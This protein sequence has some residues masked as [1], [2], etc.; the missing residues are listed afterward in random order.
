MSHR[1]PARR[2]PGRRRPRCRRGRCR[3][4][5]D[6]IVAKALRAEPAH[7]YATVGRPCGATSRRRVAA[8]ARGGTRRCTGLFRRPCLAPASLVRGGHGA[9][10]R[11]A[12][13]RARRCRLAGAPGRDGARRGAARRPRAEEALR[14]HLT[15]LF[16]SA[17]ADHGASSPTAKNMLDKSAR[18][19]LDE[20]RDQPVLAGP[21]GADAGRSLRGAGGRGRLGEP[22]RGLPGGGRPGGRSVRGGRRAPEARRH[23]A[24]AWPHRAGRPAARPVG[25]LLGRDRRAAHRGAARRHERARALAAR[26]GRPR[27]LDRARPG[28]DP[29]AH[30]VL[31]PTTTARRRPPG[32]RLRSPWPRPIAST[33]RWR[34]TG[35]RS[36]STDKL[37]LGEGL[38]AQI[39]RGNMGTLAPARGPPVRGRGAAARRDRARAG[40]R[41]RL[42]RGRRLARL[43]REEADD[44]RRRGGGPGD[45]GERPSP[46]GTRYTRDRPAR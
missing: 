39:I 19:V 17:I 32:T 18:R 23:R 16:R 26:H 45:P 24:V 46:I 43:R 25:A 36:P 4:D 29:A 14:Y 42:R 1:S 3:G 6:A 12:R 41:R 10:D 15:G 11:L 28:D 13:D 9:R 35:K 27:R 5:L 37:G 20:Y 22:A 40:A 7:R 34:P 44:R 30:R 38:D 31:G 8:E 33:N 2:R 21:G